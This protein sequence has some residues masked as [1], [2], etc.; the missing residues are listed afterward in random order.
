VVLTV[1]EG[2]RWRFHSYEGL[3]QLANAGN[4]TLKK[5][6]GKE[7]GMVCG[8]HLYGDRDK[9]KW[10]PHLDV[11]IVEEKGVRLK[12]SGEGLQA[13]K[14]TWRRSLTGMGCVDV[15]ENVFYQYR[16]K[17]A[18]KGH[19]VKYVVRPTWDGE[20]LREVDDEEKKFLVLDLK[21]FRHVRYWGSLSHVKYHREGLAN[22]IEEA[23]EEGEALIGKKLHFRAIVHF[24]VDLL[25]EKGVIEKIADGFYRIVKN[26]LTRERALVEGLT[27]IADRSVGNA[28][29][30][31]SGI[32]RPVA[33]ELK[34]EL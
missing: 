11:M 10:N 3:N 12:L 24:N 5:H 34:H 23:K 25:T 4:R 22:T 20:T 33:T 27:A 31:Q 17:P 26:R 13:V 8:I 15:S 32:H 1:P 30:V 19:C 18:H 28:A 2:E 21:G 29:G 16:M 9:A 7:V 14:D 6:F